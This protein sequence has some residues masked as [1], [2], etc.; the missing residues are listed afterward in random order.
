MVGSLGLPLGP[1]ISGDDTEIKVLS[2]GVRKRL[3]AILRE[4][5][6]K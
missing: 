2:D 6:R 5:E 3:R 1:N 4:L